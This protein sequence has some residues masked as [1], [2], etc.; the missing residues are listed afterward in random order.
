MTG[1]TSIPD[2]ELRLLQAVRLK[3]RLS[4]AAAATVAGSESDD[5]V[6]RLASTMPT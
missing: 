6:E 2:T 3:G 1:A 5:L 4:E